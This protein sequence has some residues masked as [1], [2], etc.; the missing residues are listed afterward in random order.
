MP[1][2]KAEVIIPEGEA[3]CNDCNHR[4]NTYC[5]AYKTQLRV[6]EVNRCKRRKV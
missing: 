1:K 5:R 4:V 6:L 2:R 3:R